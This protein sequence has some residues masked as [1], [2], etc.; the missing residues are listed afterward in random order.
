MEIII[1]NKITIQDVPID[2]P[3]VDG[4]FGRDCPIDRFVIRDGAGP[5]PRGTGLYV[6]TV[7]PRQ[8]AFGKAC[9]A[10][11]TSIDGVQNT[12]EISKANALAQPLKET[13]AEPEPVEA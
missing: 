9:Y 6:H 4:R 2:L 10:V 3:S 1:S 13:V 7:S 8:A 11:L 5:L 12:V